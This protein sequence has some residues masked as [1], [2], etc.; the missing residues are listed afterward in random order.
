MGEKNLWCFLLLCGWIL[1]NI[2]YI[3]LQQKG[4]FEL[5]YVF[6][7]HLFMHSKTS[8][9][10][11]QT[12]SGR[13]QMYRCSVIKWNSPNIMHDKHYAC[14]LFCITHVHT[15][16][17]IESVFKYNLSYDAFGISFEIVI[18]LIRGI[19]TNYFG[20]QCFWETPAQSC[21]WRAFLCIT[22]VN[23]QWVQIVHKCV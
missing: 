8:L 12:S 17:E 13:V 21:V 11:P 1:H 4:I 20:F 16:R 23:T 2:I 6:T 19:S 9:C 22:V 3:F 14:V 10:D 15:C 5:K 7:I 18:W